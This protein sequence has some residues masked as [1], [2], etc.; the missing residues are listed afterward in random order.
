MFNS[1]HMD[2]NIIDQ[3]KNSLN[4][5]HFKM[6]TSKLRQKYKFSK[7]YFLPHDFFD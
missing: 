6:C 3:E 7:T 4:F 2:I 1:A 5:F